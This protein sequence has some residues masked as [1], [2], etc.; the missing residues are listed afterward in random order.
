[1]RTFVAIELDT[2]IKNILSALIQKLN[3]SNTN[4]RWIKSQGM[5]LTL[6]FLGEV[7][8][9]KITEVESVLGDIAADS[10]PFPL[11]LK[12]TG[13]F[14]SGA[15]IP[16]IV[17]IGIEKNENLKNIQTR[18][19]NELHKI[20]FPKE[21]RNFHPHLTLGRVKGLQNLQP[22]I[23][24]LSEYKTSD[25]GI[26]SVDRL[27]LFKSTLKPSGAEYTILSEHW[28]E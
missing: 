3:T 25:F 1:M 26:M 17:W 2:K 11:H 20:R 5:H 7:G 12:G 6:K 21:K 28:L 16:R 9:S 8:E 27:T 4:I 14:P 13:T 18:V 23:K 10:S 15:R 19:E 24:T 22:V